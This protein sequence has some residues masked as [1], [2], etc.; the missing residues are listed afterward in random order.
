MK[1]EDNVIQEIF[2]QLIKKN[3]SSYA[4]SP[5]WKMTRQY[6]FTNEIPRRRGVR[7]WDGCGEFRC[8]FRFVMLWV[9]SN[10]IC[11]QS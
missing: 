4:T 7:N 10:P 3:T 2:D 5:K 11:V 1:I 9:A 8:H 6:R